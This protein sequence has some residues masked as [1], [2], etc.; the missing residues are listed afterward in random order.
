MLNHV[1]YKLF[2]Y[3]KGN[4]INLYIYTNLRN[5]D[6]FIVY[7][8]NFKKFINDFF[9]LFLNFLIEEI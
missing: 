5:N 4:I 3:K 7:L 6:L 1:F 2:H 8:E 9:N